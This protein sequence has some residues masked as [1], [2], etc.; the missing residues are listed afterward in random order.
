MYNITLKNNSDNT[1]LRFADFCSE[2]KMFLCTENKAY[3]SIDWCSNNVVLHTELKHVESVYIP[4][5]EGLP[6]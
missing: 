5:P 6:L 2:S 3:Q 1:E 4:E